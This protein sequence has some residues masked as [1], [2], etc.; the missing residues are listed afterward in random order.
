MHPVKWYSPC[1]IHTSPVIIFIDKTRIPAAELD[2]FIFRTDGLHYSSN[3][4]G[5]EIHPNSQREKR[6]ESVL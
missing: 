6:G 2:N 3:L 5:T 1:I 4:L